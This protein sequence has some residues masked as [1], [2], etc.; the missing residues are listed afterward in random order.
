MVE[1]Q[2]L[3]PIFSKD[4]T[5]YLQKLFSC[6]SLQDDRIQIKRFGLSYFINSVGEDKLY[7]IS[8]ILDET[9][10]NSLL[11]VSFRGSMC[12]VLYTTI[13]IEDVIT[14][15]FTNE[16]PLP[17]SDAYLETFSFIF[18][19]KKPH[20]FTN[21]KLKYTYETDDYRDSIS[22]SNQENSIGSIFNI[23]GINYVSSRGKINKFL[24]S[25]G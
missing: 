12:G 7:N 8:L 17:I 6:C 13:H 14:L 4:N 16:S 11:S 18:I 23:N 1:K 9:L 15:P 2:I 5:T 21:V 24:H 3:L 20:P 10:R 25:I 19:F 22:T